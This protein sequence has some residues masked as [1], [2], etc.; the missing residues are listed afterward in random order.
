MRRRNQPERRGNSPLLT[1]KNMTNLKYINNLLAE[2]TELRI[3]LERAQKVLNLG[4]NPGGDEDTILMMRSTLQHAAND[5]RGALAKEGK[6]F[7]DSVNELKTLLAERDEL[8]KIVFTVAHLAPATR[9]F[10]PGIGAG[11]LNGL[12]G[13]AKSALAKTKEAK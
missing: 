10:N 3:A 6:L 8:L 5:C 2:R 11:M 1:E 12:I 13:S 4:F 7:C 9:E